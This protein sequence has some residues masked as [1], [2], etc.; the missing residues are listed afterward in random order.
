MMSRLRGLGV[1]VGLAIVV[2]AGAAVV[3]S[4]WGP[5]SSP[6]RTE[7]FDDPLLVAPVAT[8][9]DLAVNST[10]TIT[11]AE[12][13]PVASSVGGVVTRIAVR[14]DDMVAA[15][16]RVVS[17]DDRPLVAFTG[18]APLVRA[19]S[20]G[21]QGPD[22]RRLQTFLNGLQDPELMVDGQF[23]TGT[24][25][26]VMGLQDDL[27]VAATGTVG[28]GDLIWIGDGPVQVRRMLVAVGDRV[29]PGAGLFEGPV[30]DVTARLP[31]AT[32]QTAV[33]AD[34]ARE[35]VL[36][37]PGAPEV[38][39]QPD[40]T[41]AMPDARMLFEHVG[42]VESLQGTV[43]LVDPLE[44]IEVP[45]AAVRSDD[46]GTCVVGADGEPV[47]VEVLTVGFGRA[48]LRPGDVGMPEQVTVDPVD[49]VGSCP[50]S[51]G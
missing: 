29:E 30:I 31:A 25:A 33:L 48:L 49:E 13:R 38:P 5:G 42:A 14:T 51:G 27:G 8:V 45:S 46:A 19:L 9:N 43:A 41:I 36:R 2:A 50:T 23:G 16:D 47:A 1:L 39:V 26:A 3:V 6:L 11:A 32:S 34:P 35:A 15:G 4:L 21:T 17:V 20:R 22:V 18:D 28:P 44:V 10:V 7:P 24:E 37:V 12:P 40:G